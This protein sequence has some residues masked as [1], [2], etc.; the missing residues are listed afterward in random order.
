MAQLGNTSRAAEHLYAAHKNHRMV[1]ANEQI[2]RR[3]LG[4][5]GLRTLGTKDVQPKSPLFI[6]SGF[7]FLVYLLQTSVMRQGTPVSSTVVGDKPPLLGWGTGTSGRRPTRA[8]L[9]A[10]GMRYTVKVTPFT[11]TR[12]SSREVRIRLAFLYVAYFSRGTLSQ[13]SV[14]G[15][16]WGT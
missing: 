16:Y 9:V 15:H 6:T 1:L 7:A 12:S 11:S 14:K 5:P 2:V 4:G 13:K 3:E 8:E 10:C